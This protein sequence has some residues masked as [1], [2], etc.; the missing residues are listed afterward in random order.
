AANQG[1]ERSQH[2]L[3]YCYENGLGTIQDFV[4]AFYWYYQASQVNYAPALIALASCYELGQGTDI[5][6]KAARQ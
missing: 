4:K 3:G 5:D 2:R 6:L 1:H